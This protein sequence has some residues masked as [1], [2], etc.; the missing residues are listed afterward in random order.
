MTYHDPCADDPRSLRSACAD[1]PGPFRRCPFFFVLSLLFSKS[2]GKSTRNHILVVFTA[3]VTFLLLISGSWKPHT[4][5]HRHC[6][7]FFGH[8]DSLTVLLLAYGYA[9]PQQT[10]LAEQMSGSPQLERH[11]RSMGIQ[12]YP[13]PM[14]LPGGICKGFLRDY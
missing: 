4:T 8:Q 11:Q 2:S 7:P 3:S 12:R 14:P 9:K 6:P 13:R 10:L 5:P 1:D